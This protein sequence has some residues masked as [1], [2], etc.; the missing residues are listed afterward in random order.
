MVAEAL[1]VP[2]VIDLDGTLIKTDSLDETLLDVL[3]IDPSAL[4]ALPYTLLR[5]RPATKAYLASRSPLDVGAWPVNDD[6]LGFIQNEVA[7]GRKIV[8]A[9]AADQSVAQ[10]IAKRF[11]FISEVIASDGR[12][13]LKG[14]AKA[15]KLRERFPGGFIYAGNSAA[16]LHV[17]REGSDSV[18]VNA[19]AAV[20]RK[21]AQHREPLAVFQG[22]RTRP[23]LSGAASGCISGRRMH[24]F[25]SHSSSE[26]DPA[27]SRRGSTLS[28]DSS[29]SG[30]PLR[31]PMSSTI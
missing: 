21:A 14:R 8:L 31:Q 13:N 6:F 2:L 28:S 10:A 22:P 26:D 29:R 15:A 20:L 25:S 16:D 4:L 19:P 24:L 7:R 3:R 1:I 12:R 11:D 17:W 27:M 9:T 18:I 5:G 30:L 23:Q